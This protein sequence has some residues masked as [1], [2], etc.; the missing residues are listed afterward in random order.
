LETSLAGKGVVV[1]RPRELADALAARIEQAGGTAWR[2]PAIEILP[3][4]DE[5]AARATLGR[6][7]QFDAAIFVSP[8]AARRAA[9]LLP[10]WPRGIAA[11]AVGG[12]T[13]AELTRAG[14]SARAPDAGADSEALLELPLLREVA[15]RRFLI[16]CGEGGRELLAET[17]R[18][19]GATVERAELYRRARPNA[20]PQPLLDAWDARRIHAVLASSS[21]GVANLFALLGEA[22]AGRLR[23]TPLFVPHPR[24]AE[25]ARGLGARRV[26]IA[27][28]SDD[29]TLA[30]LV[31]YFAIHD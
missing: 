26:E 14:I 5:A 4:A 30:R 27:G 15:G 2:F 1:T 19:R 21:E 22:G 28:P 25:A 16:V 24:V 23:A 12:G 8:T 10:A 18:A 7:A 9:P 31:A 17:L 29:E 6:L 3:P 11:F 13:R 20:D